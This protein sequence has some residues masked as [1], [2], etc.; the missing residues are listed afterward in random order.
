M[1]NETQTE[2]G[3]EGVNW[4]LFKKKEGGGQFLKLGDGETKIIGIS[5]IKMVMAKYE[6]E[7]DDGS[8]KIEEQ[9]EIHLVLDS[10]DGKP[11]PEGMVFSTGAK[12]LV[13][14]IKEFDASKML[15]QFYFKLER[16]GLKMNTKYVF[17]PIKPKQ[18]AGGNPSPSLRDAIDKD[19][20]EAFM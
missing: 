2:L 14:Q 3:N 8:K 9:P 18:A 17:V 16:H 19:P 10:L 11:A 20:T 6:R 12:Y 13:A 7:Q 1:A 4:E 15:Y 5:K